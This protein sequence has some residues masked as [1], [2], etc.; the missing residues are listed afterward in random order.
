MTMRLSHGYRLESVLQR[1]NNNLDLVRL[2]CALLVI[3]GH[4]YLV[5]PAASTPPAGWDWFTLLG[6]PGVYSA[7]VAV[8]VFFFI[9]GLLVTDSLVRK[10]SVSGFLLSR[11][12]RVWP[13]LAVLVTFT[14]L[15][16]GPLLTTWDR[17]DYFGSEATYRYVLHN[18][19][20][21]TVDA[22]PGVF[23]GNPDAGQ[24]NGSLWTLRY[25]IAAYAWLLVLF[26]T[27]IMRRRWL[28]TVLLVLVCADPLL[29]HP[30]LP[31]S[32]T[33]NPQ[34]AYLPPCFALGACLALWKEHVVLRWEYLLLGGMG[35]ALLHATRL[36]P[37]LFIFVLLFA[38]LYFSATPLARRLL[39]PADISYGT[40]L[41][42]FLVQQAVASQLADAGFVVNIFFSLLLTLILAWCSW[43]LVEKPALDWARRLTSGP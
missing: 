28:C 17:G 35:L 36:G 19:T 21:N 25:E 20:L 9:S 29:T 10:G 32:R 15:A 8:K 2:G 31:T 16:A 27:G 41:W 22:L 12:L 39:L 38:A 5:L 33:G 40:Y 34:I 7:S 37:L 3:F 30:L 6:Y 24:V 18:L 42:G 23:T 14:A 26:A 1:S 4:S 43:H 11:F 13:A